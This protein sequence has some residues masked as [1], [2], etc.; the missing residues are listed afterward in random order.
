MF[1]SCHEPG[2][3]RRGLVTLVKRNIKAIT[4][5]DAVSFGDVETMGITITT[6]QQNI[7]IYNVYNSPNHGQLDLGEA[8]HHASTHPT[9]IAG[10]INAH[11]PC[12]NPPAI[13]NKTD[14]AGTHIHHMLAQYPGVV[15]M[16]GR[17]P[18]HVR[19][20]TLDLIFG[21]QLLSNNHQW[22]VHNHLYSDHFATVTDINAYAIPQPR[23]V[24]RW[25]TKKADWVK[26]QDELRSWKE[27]FSHPYSLNEHNKQVTE[28]FNAA[29][30]KAI[31]PTKPCV[32]HKND[33][34]YYDKRVEEL[35][36]RLNSAKSN[37][38]KNK[39]EK[40]FELFQA[41][42][43]LINQE[44]E[45]I[46]NRKWLEWCEQINAHTNISSL[47]AHLNRARGRK[48]T[49]LPNHPDPAGEAQ[50]LMRHFK[51]RR[52]TCNLPRKAINAM[53]RLKPGRE[54]LIQ[55]ACSS[56]D[57]SMDQP[58]TMAELQAVLKT[59]RDTAP[60][61][62]KI[63]HSMVYNAGPEGHQAILDL[64]NHSL[65]AGALPE[66]W[67]QSVLVPIPKP[68]GSQ[69][70]IELLSCI[71]K[72]MEKMVKRRLEHR[73]GPL[74]HYVFAYQK[75]VG[76]QDALAA[77]NYY[78]SK[79]NAV[80]VTLDLEKAFELCN[81]DV[82]LEALV[83]KGIKGHILKWVKDF[84]SHRKSHTTYQ[85][86]SSS[87]VEFQQGTPMG[88]SLSPLLFNLVMERLL[89]YPHG[90]NIHAICFAD[91]LTII[92]IGENSIDE[93]TATLQVLENRCA[94]LG[95]KINYKKS[96]AIKTKGPTPNRKMKIQNRPIDW[97]DRQRILGVEMHKSLEP[98]GQIYGIIERLKPRLNVMRAM[99]SP[100]LGLN[101]GVLKTFY[102]ACIRSIIDYSALSIATAKTEIL[103]KLEIIQNEALRIMAK[104][105]RW[106]KLVNLRME[107]DLV[108]I[109][110]RIKE[111]CASFVTKSLKRGRLTDLNQ[112]IL[113]C[114]DPEVDVGEAAAAA[115]SYAAHMAQC[116]EDMGVS[117][118]HARA[119]D[120][121]HPGFTP[122][123]PWEAPLFSVTYTTAKPK[124]ALTQQDTQSIRTTVDRLAQRPAYTAYFT[125]G[126]VH[127][128]TTHAACSV[129]TTDHTAS[130]RLSDGASTLQT[131][132]AAILKALQFAVDG[133]GD[134]H[135][136]IF[137][138]S[139]AAVK[140]LQHIQT[141]DNRYLLTSILASAQRLRLQGRAVELVWLPSHIGVDGNERAD[142]AANDGLM[143]PHVY[144]HVA[145]TTSKLK[146]M[147]QRTARNIT[148]GQHNAE[149]LR[150]SRS[151]EWY[152]H[153]TGMQPP[154]I[155]PDTPRAVA[156]IIHR[157]RL[158]YPCW[159]EI[160][161]DIRTCEYCNN[162]AADD[163]L[164]HYLLQCPATDRLRH[165]VGRRR[166]AAAAAA[167]DGD[168]RREAAAL[169]RGMLECPDALLFASSY[170]PPK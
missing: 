14:A 135:V 157:L 18:T 67:K 25:N 101:Y 11:H 29:A 65:A 170:P 145:P 19:G 45:E 54:R 141:E 73:I 51:Q 89:D 149:V 159:E 20:A 21:S 70:P 7:D 133:N 129:V 41:T 112:E 108:P 66:T 124:H 59:G 1:K 110:V 9:I 79:P 34:W 111:I 138:D 150:H 158:G 46:R 146:S 2:N 35:R 100:K 72:A 30:E 5:N 71:N 69:R 109:T 95:L 94:E 161:G 26:F 143:L 113:L 116:L 118:A 52:N 123:A 81:K 68:D 166:A 169:V 47:W 62:D 13:A 132:M 86:H 130:Y 16:N 4:I 115:S 90:P 92:A 61:A 33:A 82:M 155:T 85:G 119:E 39:T 63:T 102:I 121:P 64:V 156:V 27:A 36:H 23:F 137:T 10:D 139:L 165:L 87:V 88:S 162:I 50:A 40:N 56:P 114:M 74:K 37:L 148:I 142:M 96:K 122:P 80:A 44:L 32:T 55:R 126:S 131:E 91:D 127:P 163:A 17:E 22:H 117:L 58:F 76:S 134:K 15:M 8:F 3:N 42:K 84:L 83:N 38:M 106:S 28:A 144:G 152:R 93:A 78:L 120:S 167:A 140:I 160:Q 107:M 168:S 77:I 125:D 12:L 6:R 53:K 147:I 60:G 57:E 136:A 153:A 128:D 99:T 75:Q 98:N 151:A 105:P 103:Y 97:T 48:H 164:V 24:R 154:P 31:P 43:K 49:P 104:A